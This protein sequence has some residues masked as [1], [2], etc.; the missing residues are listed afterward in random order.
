MYKIITALA[1]LEEQKVTPETTFFCK[2]SYDFLHK[3]R[4]WKKYGHGNVNIYTALEQS[5]D[6]YFYHLGHRLGINTLAHY[7]RLFGLGSSTGIILEGEK[8]G[9]VPTTT[10]KRTFD[11]I[12]W[13]DGETLSAAIGQSFLL[14]TPLQTAVLINT[15]SNGGYLY[16]PNLVKEITTVHN[17]PIK[18]FE[19]TL[20]LDNMV[21]TESL[22]IVRESLRRVVQNP[23]GTG[24][25]AQIDGIELAGKTGTAQVV[26]LPQE[27][28]DDEEIPYQYRDHAWFVAF[29]P[30]DDPKISVAVLIEHGR[31]GSSAAGPV[32]REIIRTYLDKINNQK[33]EILL[34]HNNLTTQSF[35]ADKKVVGRETFP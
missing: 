30:F 17:H 9:L 29:A 16:T 34:E 27:K 3:P 23:R 8:P 10:W 15:V 12:P 32:A 25:I 5:C 24:K 21:S 11:N 6:V 18:T 13:Q 2:G 31:F 7:S 26:R 20:V 1:G 35:P 14:V 19:P 4:C 28:K 22:D 33:Q